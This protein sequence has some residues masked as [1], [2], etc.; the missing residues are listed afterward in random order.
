MYAD[1]G[2]IKIKH[3]VLTAVAELAFAGKLEEE[4]QYLPERL[5]PGPQAQFR[6]CIYKEREIIRERA[7]LA[8]G[9][10]PGEHD[11]GN[12][13]HVIHAAC[14]D[15][16]ISSYVVTDNCQNCL[17]K[18][19]VN[20]CKFDACHPGEH[21]SHIDPAKCKECGKCAQACPYHAIAALK[22]P[23]KFSC[24][25]DAISY[26]EYGISV[27]DE[28][29]CIRCGK[30]IHSCP[31]GAIGSKAYIVPV[32]NALKSGK[33][34]YAMTAPATEGQF[35]PK[36]TQ[37]SWKV[38]MKKLGFEDFIEV[39]LGGDLTAKAEAD[40]W[41]EA[42]EKG[43]KKT[44]SC[45]PAF[46]NMIR[47]HYPELSDLIS[48]A[49]SP[50]AAVSRMI[51]ARD[52]EAICVFIGPCISKKSEA[53]EQGIENNAD[54]VLTFSEIRAIM[55]A[56][57]VELEE[58][59]SNDYQESSIFGKR[60]SQT[61]GV[62]AAVIQSLKES[63]K[64]IEPK[65]CVANGAAECKKALLLMKVGR[66]S[67]D[68]LEGMV[69]E[70][71]CVGGTSAYRERTAFAKDRETLFATADDRLLQENLKNYDTSGFSMH[72]D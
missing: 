62:T 35:G 30:C 27:I 63:E 69:C 19:C 68:F 4:V 56:K 23:C 40:E 32:I 26:D 55:R 37:K 14:E 15:C 59:E 9:M 70:G 8:M 29:K 60:F 66:F 67:D 18:A 6:C 13:I 72:R 25:V 44:T 11:D 28:E 33:R 49:I 36:I 50:M 58:D 1:E 17:G 48:T 12:L 61:G 22:R 45:C 64:H 34:V 24:P 42:Y 52:P 16:P 39:G 54:Y 65:V 2:V 71:G 5:I 7:R 31:F 3:D 46:V 57:G 20:A 47:K 53:M 43:E 21:R 10:A 51:K 38:A 41:A